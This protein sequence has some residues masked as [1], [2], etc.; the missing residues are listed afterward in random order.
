MTVKGGL[1]RLFHISCSQVQKHDEREKEERVLGWR[2]NRAQ[3]KPPPRYIS[4]WFV[5]RA[6]YF[7]GLLEK[8]KFHKFPERH[9]DL[10]SSK[11]L[12]GSRFQ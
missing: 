1:L 5:D 10:K 7:G 2:R 4:D 12:G 6:D 8:W 9:G 3:I 11:T